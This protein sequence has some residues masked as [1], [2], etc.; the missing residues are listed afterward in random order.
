MDPRVKAVG[1]IFVL[2]LII[3][4]H[5]SR[6]LEKPR[7][8]T[9]ARVIA[10]ILYTLGA[11]FFCISLF[12]IHTPYGWYGAVVGFPLSAIGIIQFMVLRRR[13]SELLP[14]WILYGCW[15]VAMSILHGVYLHH[16]VVNKTSLFLAG[17]PATT[18]SERYGWQLKPN[19]TNEPQLHRNYNSRFNTD[20]NGRRITPTSN[21]NGPTVLVLGGSFTFGSG[22]NDRQTIPSVVARETN[23]NV[24][25]ASAG[26]W[27][28]IQALLYLQ[29]HGKVLKPKI[30]V[31]CSIGAHMGRN[32]IQPRYETLEA[33]PRCYI[34]DGKLVIHTTSTVPPWKK[35]RPQEV[36][37]HQAD[38]TLALLDLLAKES[39]SLGAHFVHVVLSAE[40]DTFYD[41]RIMYEYSRDHPDITVIDCRDLATPEVFFRIDGHMNAKGNE[42]CGTRIAQE[43]K[44][45]L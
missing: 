19:L 13:Q 28:T 10:L 39:K 14:A 21:Q 23:T 7:Y 44:K 4:V 17:S 27:G 37:N 29:E 42:L 12:F 45:L 32:Y 9:Y 41:S 5:I 15:L 33:G 8:R 18:N 43:L 31:Y 36:V 16:I 1:G 20:Q 26:G 6:S 22:V 2:I 25:N 24:I 34:Q 40:S 38:A 11:T 35:E 3:G 30:V